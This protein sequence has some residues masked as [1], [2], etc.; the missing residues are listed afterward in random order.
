MPLDPVPLIDRLAF[1]QALRVPDRN[2]VTDCHR[3]C[4]MATIAWVMRVAYSAAPTCFR[5]A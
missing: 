1:A 3:S 4:S 2:L 5:R